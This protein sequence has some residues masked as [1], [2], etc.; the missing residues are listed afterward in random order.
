MSNFFYIQAKKTR[1]IISNDNNSQKNQTG[2]DY[3]HSITLQMDASVGLH[4]EPVGS[5]SMQLSKYLVRDSTAPVIDVTTR[6]FFGRT[7]LH[8]AV[9]VGNVA[10]VCELLC[11]RADINADSGFGGTPLYTALALGRPAVTA[12]L[13][14]MSADV[15]IYDMDSNGKTPLMM[16]IE[17]TVCRGCIPSLLANR[18]DVNARLHSGWTALHKATAIGLVDVVELLLKAGA[19]VHSKS[20]ENHVPIYYA[21]ILGHVEIFKLLADAGSDMSEIEGVVFGSY[22]P[23]LEVMEVTYTRL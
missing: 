14:D 23:D 9:A 6:D 19:D 10:S 18:A 8:K 20:D 2:V 21:A 11:A 22:K 5:N 3:P 7:P 12:L 13:I 15:N 4:E 1:R 17:R 16:A